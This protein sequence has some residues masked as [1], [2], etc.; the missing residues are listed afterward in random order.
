MEA[1]T[2]SNGKGDF[3]SSSLGHMLLTTSRT[4]STHTPLSNSLE[5]FS[6]DYN[7]KK[8]RRKP[9]GWKINI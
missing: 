2:S 8:R 3:V 4:I 1:A 5:G 9:E 6:N 7:T